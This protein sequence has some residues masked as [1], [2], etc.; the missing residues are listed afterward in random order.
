MDLT[1]FTIGIFA[2]LLFATGAVAQEDCKSRGELDATY[3]DENRDLVADAPKDAKRLKNPST[4]VFAYTPIEDPAVYQNLFKPFQEHLQACTGKKV[5]YFTVQSNAAQ[6][7]AMRAG[8]LHVTGLAS[9]QVGFAVNLAG[10][11]PFAIKGDQK[12][13]RTYTQVVIVKRDS[14]YQKLADLK[15]KKVA[16]TAPSSNSGNLAPRALFPAEGLTPDKDYKVLYSGKHDQ[17]LMGVVNGDYD[18]APITSDI[19]DRFI[20]R[21]IIKEGDLRIIYKSGRFPTS[22][23]AHSHDLEPQLAAQVKKCFFDYRFSAEMKKEF[24]GDDRFLPISYKDDWALVRK[25][26]E[27]S[28]TPYN[29][30]G[31]D[32]ERAAEEAAR[33]KK[34]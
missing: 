26:A 3:C 28:G 5:V 24:L 23:F 25:V 7:E 29:K 12:G 8:R 22:A 19:Y 14:P 15:G 27:D 1:R 10:A 13:P 18:A 9:G 20:N 31:F 4:L 34:K 2:A 17:S 6:I 30:A 11:V 21:G 33:A 32:K 16:H